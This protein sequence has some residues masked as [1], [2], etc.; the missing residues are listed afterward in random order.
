MAKTRRLIPLLLVAAF[1]AC[2]APEG[3]VRA[4]LISAGVP[5]PIAGC[6]AA[7]MSDR[8][9]LAQLRRLG[10]IGKARRTRGIDGLIRELRALDDP[11]IVDVTATAAA[12]C[13]SGLAR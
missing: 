10:K 9:S 7:R 2:S 8:L 3:Q 11:E 13:A 6:M 1:A 5:Q 12:L 4:G